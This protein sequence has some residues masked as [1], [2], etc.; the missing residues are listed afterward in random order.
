MY[1]PE[2][3]HI[4]SLFRSF[5][6][7]RLVI[8]DPQQGTCAV[9][10][11]ISRL[12]VDV[13]GMVPGFFSVTSYLMSNMLF[14][15]R[16]QSPSSLFLS[17]GGSRNYRLSS[18]ITRIEEKCWVQLR[19]CHCKWE[20]WSGWEANPKSACF[21]RD[22][23]NYLLSCLSPFVPASWKVFAMVC[24]SALDRLCGLVVRVLGYRSGGP[25]S[26]P[27]TTRN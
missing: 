26:I 22:L 8:D 27:V 18:V 19:H 5:I 24:R 13:L 10:T 7:R 11:S 2:I 12:V 21:I 14:W 16:L 6:I 9:K 15:R 23:V 17:E 4:R 20:C 3:D 25:G 1:L